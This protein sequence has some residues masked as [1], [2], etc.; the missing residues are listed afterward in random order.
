MVLYRLP[1][2]WELMGGSERY[3]NNTKKGWMCNMG[4]QKRGSLN[5][6]ASRRVVTRTERGWAGHFICCHY[7]N[8]R[9]NTL[10]EYGDIR[11]VVSTVGNMWGPQEQTSPGKVA[12]NAYYETMCFHSDPEDSKY[13]DA[14]VEQEISIMGKRY[15]DHPYADDEANEMH[16]DVVAEMTL[17]L[18]ASML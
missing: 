4:Y 9:R 5:R 6:G 1:K 12:L 8:F 11:L 15:I 2:K 3:K 17:R 13:H 14:D 16:E 18:I 7:C 10:L